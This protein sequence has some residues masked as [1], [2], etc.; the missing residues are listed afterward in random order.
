MNCFFC[1]KKLFY[2]HLSVDGCNMFDRRAED[3]C[4]RVIYISI[5]CMGKTE[6]MNIDVHATYGGG[7]WLYPST[8]IFI[9][10]LKRLTETGTKFEGV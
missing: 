8:G 6:C 9:N 2:K 4:E 10:I 7:I 5:S 1:G 3:S